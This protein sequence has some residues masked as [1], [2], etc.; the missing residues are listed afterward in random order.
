MMKSSLN[1]LIIKRN[2]MKN[3]IYI[4]ALALAATAFTGCSH[5]Y[6]YDGEYDIA[7]YFH[8]SDPR[9]NLVSFASTT[10]K[11]D[12]DFAA[13]ISTGQDSHTFTFTANIS[14]NLKNATTVQVAFAA[15]APLLTT[16]Y[17]DYKVATADQVTLPNKGIFEISKELTQLNIPITVNGLKK[18]DSPTVV[19]VRITPTND[20]LKS[21]T[22]THQDYAYILIQPKEMWAAELDGDGSTVKMTA[23]GN[24]YTGSTTLNVMFATEKVVSENCKVGLERDNT[25]FKSDSGKEL[26]PEGISTTTQVDATNQQYVQATVDL[27]HAEKFTTAGE[28]VL[29]MRAVFYDKDG[30]KHNIAGGEVLIPIN[31]VDV[32]FANAAA[33][34][35]GTM[36]P[37]SRYQLSLSTPLQYGTIENLTDGDTDQY[38]YLPTGTSTLTIDLNQTTNVKGIRI[39]MY[40]LHGFEY[41]T[42]KVRVYGSTNGTKWLPLSENIHLNETTWNNINATK[43]VN[44]RY[45]KLELGVSDYLG[46]LSEIEIYK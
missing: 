16:T 42:D 18:M 39:G 32:A 15:D 40:I 24:S 8:G 44:V 20:E 33:T 22:G 12:N 21:P 23:L 37:S 10:Q 27:Q 25:L 46:S 14:R 2:N 3:N 7:G 36:I 29:P 26:A 13:G 45:L 28:Y 5:D 9:N 35:S 4:I 43:P 34:P 11:Y 6:N 38:G 30:N 17:K 31:V 41:Y 19:P 1:K